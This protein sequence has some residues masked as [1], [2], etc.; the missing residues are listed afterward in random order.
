MGDFKEI[1][2]I[3][4]GGDTPWS[5]IY[6]WSDLIG[7]HAHGG[8]GYSYPQGLDLDKKMNWF[9]RLREWSRARLHM[10]KDRIPRKD[11]RT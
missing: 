3:T 4:D 5:H 2:P 7:P 9:V 1:I 8:Y 6:R 11:R 10:L